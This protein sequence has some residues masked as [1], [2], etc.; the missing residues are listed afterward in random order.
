VRWA[1]NSSAGHKSA[2]ADHRGNGAA[3]KTQPPEWPLTG[4]LGGSAPN[5][6]CV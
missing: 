6:I 2:A 5:Q 4:I 3:D 1:R